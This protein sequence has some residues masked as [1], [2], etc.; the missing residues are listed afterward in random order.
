MR[1]F[2][3][4][5]FFML[6]VPGC[7]E[8]GPQGCP[9]REPVEEAGLNEGRVYRL[10]KIVDIGHSSE[11]AVIVGLTGKYER[12]NVFLI[13]LGSF[14]T[15]DHRRL[16]LPIVEG[17]CFAVV[18]IDGKRGWVD[19]PCDGKKAAPEAPLAPPGD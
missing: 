19:V 1:T 15:S 4:V 14:D 6:A 2:I 16:K 10:A 7:G 5:T 17:R 13:R 18:K 8:W 9:R 12:R 3:L 11:Y